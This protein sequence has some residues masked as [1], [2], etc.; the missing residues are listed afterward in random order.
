MSFKSNL[1]NSVS[2]ALFVCIWGSG[3]IFTEWGLQHASA[4]AFLVLRFTIA[5][6]VLTVI[7]TPEAKTRKLNKINS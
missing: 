4:L 1:N 5:L 7:G 6:A 2:T 3:A